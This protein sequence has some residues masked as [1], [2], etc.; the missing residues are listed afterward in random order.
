MDNITA[1]LFTNN[2]GDTHSKVLSHLAL[3][4]WTWC[5]QRSITICAEHISGVDNVGADTESRKQLGLA[6]WKLNQQLFARINAKWG[7]LDVDLFAVRHNHQLQRYFSYGPDPE[8]EAVDAL[9]QNWRNPPTL[10]SD[11]GESNGP[12]S[13][14]GTEQLPTLGHLESVWRSMQTEGISKE[15]LEIISSSW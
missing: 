6:E 7:P 5:I 1:I 8:A 3:Q 12:N 13:P 11:V 9:A 10:S 14:T 2:K 15:A 4:I